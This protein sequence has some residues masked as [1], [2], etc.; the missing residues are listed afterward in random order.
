MVRERG[1]TRKRVNE[2]G[3]QDNGVL[4]SGREVVV[5]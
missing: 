2:L 5:L 3:I 4:M 1:R